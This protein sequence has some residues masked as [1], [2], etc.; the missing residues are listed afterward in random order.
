[1]GTY[2]AKTQAKGY[3]GGID[4]TREPDKEALN[5]AFNLLS[6]DPEEAL[7][8]LKALADRGSIASMLYIAHT[9]RKLKGDLL[10]SNE[11]FRRAMNAGSL[12]GSYELA[13][14]YREAN[15]HSDA[16]EVLRVG[17]SDGYAP[18]IHQLGVMYWKGLGVDKDTDKARKLFERASAL[19]HVYAKRNLGILLLT[20]QPRE[21]FRGLRLW[22]RAIKDAWQLLPD[23]PDDADDR[24]R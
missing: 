8:E 6:S 3:M 2:G 14:N 11:W 20:S 15:N 7:V 21:V 18:S 16:L 9:Y 1:M 12:L 10:Q 23:P 19:G 4:W 22:M 13:R 24:L 5:H 17:E